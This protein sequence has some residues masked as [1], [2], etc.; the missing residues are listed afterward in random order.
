MELPEAKKLFGNNFI[1]PAELN[2][3]GSVL[4]IGEFAEE[5]GNI[6]P[7]GF[8]DEILKKNAGDSILI[9]G[10]PFHKDGSKLNIKSL[11]EIFGLDPAKN[12]PC[13]YNQD[14][15]L[16][17]KFFE[18]TLENKWYLIKRGVA[19]DS[20]AKN[21][22]DLV[23]KMAKNENLPSAIL[24]ALVFFANY[25]L[26]KEILWKHDFIWCADTDFNGDRIY[27]GRYVD[28]DGKNKNGFNIHR[29]LKLRPCYGVVT[30]IS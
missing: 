22:E 17:Q 21:P 12:E 29:H 11:R 24:T 6:P 8:S 27:T 14:W 15:Y 23:N 7:I 20:R 1:G 30:E 18:E 28:P 4:N 5:N 10:A 3:I 13:F 26:N 9:L 2:K 19:E 16:G 25:L